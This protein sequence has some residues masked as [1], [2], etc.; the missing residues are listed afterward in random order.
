[1]LKWLLCLLLGHKTVAKARTGET[2]ETHSYG[3]NPLTVSLYVWKRHEFCLR[4][5]NDVP[6]AKKEE[7]THADVSVKGG[8]GAAGPDDA[9]A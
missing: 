8:C 6:H 1:M 7:G 5:G 2:Y 3:G 9:R 4:C